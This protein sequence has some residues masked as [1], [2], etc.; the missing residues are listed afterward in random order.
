MAMLNNQRVLCEASCTFGY[1]QG[2]NSVAL[3]LNVPQLLEQKHG[4][5]TCSQKTHLA[6]KSIDFSIQFGQLYPLVN[7]YSL[8]T[9]K[10]PLK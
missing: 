8:R 4:D 10:W 9:G 7:V 2:V 5:R 1:K 3:C 6:S